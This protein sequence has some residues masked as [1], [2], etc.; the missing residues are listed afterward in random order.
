MIKKYVGFTLIELLV[1]ISIISILIAILLPALRQAREA[2]RSTACQVKLRSIGMAQQ[3]YSG[4][5]KD[6][7]PYLIFNWSGGLPCWGTF[8]W[9][10]LNENEQAFKCPSFSEKTPQWIID[11]N[12]LG[13]NTYG[14]NLR[15]MD[16][17]TYDNDLD[18]N[19]GSRRNADIIRAGEKILNVE[20]WNT[21]NAIGWS[22]DRTGWSFNSGY[23]VGYKYGANAS[24]SPRNGEYHLGGSPY[25]YAD[26]H[27]SHV[28]ID[29]MIQWLSTDWP[30]KNNPWVVEK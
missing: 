22:R 12:R 23:V 4:D 11:N 14:V 6:Y 3:V 19:K 21:Y 17:M 5:N 24:G 20:A 16:S 8:M 26:G 13:V 25:Y 2:S 29:E 7:L 1:V 30:S 15:A 9:S 18:G 28:S 10:Y 27:V